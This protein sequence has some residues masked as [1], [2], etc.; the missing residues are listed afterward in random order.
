MIIVVLLQKLKDVSRAKKNVTFLI[1]NIKGL[2]VL[3]L[4]GVCQAYKVISF[5]ISV[6]L[7]K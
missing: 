6:L 5:D 2:D 7:Q 4:G 1:C 3:Y